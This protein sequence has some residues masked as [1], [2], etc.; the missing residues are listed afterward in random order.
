MTLA[1]HRLSLVTDDLRN[2]TLIHMLP[3]QRLPGFRA[4]ALLPSGR[5]VPRRVRMLIDF[6]A[7][8]LR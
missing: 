7:A 5:H 1:P 4:Y 8:Q 3:R 6:L 2:G